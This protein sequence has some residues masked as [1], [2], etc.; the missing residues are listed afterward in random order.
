MEVRQ[1]DATIATAFA[2]QPCDTTPFPAEVEYWDKAG[3]DPLT[4]TLSVNRGLAQSLNA[5]VACPHR[6]RPAVTCRAI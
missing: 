3:G 6:I 5:G 1:V 4:T 2:I